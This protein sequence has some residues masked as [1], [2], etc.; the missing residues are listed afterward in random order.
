MCI[1]VDICWMFYLIIQSKQMAFITFNNVLS[2][3]NNQ[4]SN[5]TKLDERTIR[6]HNKNC[7]LMGLTWLLA[8]NRTAYI[9]T[10]SAVIRA[11][12]MST[13]GL[14]PQSCTLSSDGKPL[15]VDSSD[16]SSQS[17]SIT[18]WVPLYLLLL[19]PCLSCMFLTGFSNKL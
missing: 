10:V 12:M 16:I 1:P 5:A 4:A 17:L 19:S 15:A 18:L 6:I 13:D 2:Q 8:K 3:L 7:Q 9:H 14:D 11:M